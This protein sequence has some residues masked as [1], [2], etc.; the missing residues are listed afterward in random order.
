[1]G[2]KHDYTVSHLKRVG[3]TLT[4]EQLELWHNNPRRI[5]LTHVRALCRMRSQ[6]RDEL[7]RK[8]LATKMTS[9]Q[10]EAIAAKR[11][12]TDFSNESGLDRYARKMSE[13]TGR[14]ISFSY[15]PALQPGKITLS[16]Q[17]YDDL[18][19]LSKNLGFD[20]QSYI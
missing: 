6:Q 19:E 17:G 14:V 13:V 15:R 7:F 9:A 3:K 16:W 8:L 1:M 5:T 11:Q 2:I 18:D 20:A 12:A 10:L 4:H